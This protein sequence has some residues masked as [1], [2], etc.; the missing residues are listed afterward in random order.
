MTDENLNTTDA[1][2]EATATGTT[3][4][5]TKQEEPRFTQAQLDQIIKERLAAERRKADEKADQA[6]KAA[7]IEAAAKN[8]EWEKLAKQ[9]EAELAKL[10]G[11]LKA[12]ELNDLKRGIAEK[13]GLPSQLAARLV[14]ETAEDIEADAKA[15]LE[16]LPKP[17][18]PGAGPVLTN[19]GSNATP[20]NSDAEMEQRLRFNGPNV[21]DLSAMKAK[22][23]GIFINE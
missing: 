19:P 10:S 21:F 18:K 1:Q 4:P 9:R 6:R 17:P 20:Q 14:G 22:G 7:E 11:D 5:E 3:A 16:T 8:G 15:L 2:P 13:I 23:G 12:R